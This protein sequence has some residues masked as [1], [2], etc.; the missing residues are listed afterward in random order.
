MPAARLGCVW[1]MGVVQDGGTVSNPA[2]SH[3]VQVRR[4]HGPGAPRPR[5]T[6][7]GQSGGAV[8]V[9]LYL[10]TPWVCAKPCLGTPQNTKVPI[11]Q[12]PPVLFSPTAAIRCITQT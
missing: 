9:C 7:A 12:C 2:L 4:S 8:C 11:S 1:G 10:Y 5:R 3:P 6:P